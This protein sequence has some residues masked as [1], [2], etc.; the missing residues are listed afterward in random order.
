[1]IAMGLFGEVESFGLEASGVIRRTGPGVQSFE[2]GDNVV[3]IGEGL[4][5]TRTVVPAQHCL[6]I[7]S[8]MPLE[9]AATMPIVFA[10]AIYS[11]ICLGGIK[12]G[13]VC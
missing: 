5:R 7:P 4:M 10:T 13:Q 2:V 12:R 3:L 11:L 8:W 9:D 6:K 1:M